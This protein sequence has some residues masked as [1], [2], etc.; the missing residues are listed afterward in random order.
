ML[1][2][3]SNSVERGHGTRLLRDANSVCGTVLES[4]S[5]DITAVI[6]GMGTALTGIPR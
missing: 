1:V 2:D 4:C 6:T 5:R 3:A